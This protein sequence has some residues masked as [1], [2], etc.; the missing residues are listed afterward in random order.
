MAKEAN[1]FKFYDGDAPSGDEAAPPRPVL[2]AE[3]TREE[4]LAV[5]DTLR[6]GVLQTITGATEVGPDDMITALEQCFEL[7]DIKTAFDVEPEWILGKIEG[8]SRKQRAQLL[9]SL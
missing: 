7:M 5:R 4:L 1:P 8:M 9:S 2:K 6:S 3:L